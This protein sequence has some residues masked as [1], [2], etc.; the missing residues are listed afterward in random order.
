MPRRFHPGVSLRSLETLVHVR[1]LDLVDQDFA[2]QATIVT[3]LKSMKMMIGMMSTIVNVPTMIEICSLTTKAL[4]IEM[5]NTWT[6]RGIVVEADTTK[7][8]DRITMLKI[9]GTSAVGDVV[10]PHHLMVIGQLAVEVDQ[11]IV[12]EM[13]EAV[14]VGQKNMV[15]AEAGVVHHVTVAEVDVPVAHQI[16]AAEEIAAVVSLLKGGARTDCLHRIILKIRP[17][18]NHPSEVI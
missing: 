14:T 7:N 16:H 3:T 4:M 12:N 1:H 11:G 8:D 10:H 18:L 6:E 13:V 2:S 15:A 9:E 17:R 5:I